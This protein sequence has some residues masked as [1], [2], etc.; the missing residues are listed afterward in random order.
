MKPRT[1]NQDLTERFRPAGE[2]MG[3]TRNCSQCGKNHISLGGK[4]CKRTKMWRCAGCVE[5][6]K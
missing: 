3:F 5:E 1:D 4:T 2:G 6:V